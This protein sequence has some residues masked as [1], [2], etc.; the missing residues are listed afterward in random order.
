[1]N[2]SR[3]KGMTAFL[4]MLWILLAGFGAM[5]IIAYLMIQPPAKNA[6]VIKRAE[7][8]I[9]LEWEQSSPDDVDLWVMNPKGDVVSFRGKSAGFMNLEKDDLGW[10]ND[11]IT[12][13]YGVKT[14]IKINREVVT[15][16]GVVAGEYQVMLHVFGRKFLGSDKGFVTTPTEFTIEVIKINPYGVVYKR[17]AVY[18]TRG[19]EISLVRFTV[20]KDA[21]FLFFNTLDSDFIS[22]SPA[23]GGYP[24]TGRDA[25]AGRLEN[26]RELH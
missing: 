10:S 3:F 6:D 23:S 7:Y 22:S 17:S 26:D 21:D 24:S 14:I 4:D 11:T 13:E 19:Q 20:N 18:T 15:L 9:V 25:M 16:R 1:M 2:K 5:F 8:I 12:D